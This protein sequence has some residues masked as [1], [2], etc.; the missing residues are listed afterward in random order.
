M[1]PSLKAGIVALASVAL[2]TAAVPAAS[3][4]S[5]RNVAAVG[6]TDGG[7]SLVAFSTASTRFRGAARA[8]TG[9]TGDTRLVGIDR[10]V[11][12]RKLYGVGDRGGVYTLGDRGA[13][14]KVLQLTVALSGT[15][16]GV[17]F[18]PAAN[19]L[20]IVSDTGQNL[21]QPFATAGAAT[22][23]DGALT[24]PAVAPATGTVPA[25]G[26]TGAAYT[27]ND[28]DA[29]SSTTLFDL[30]TALDRVALQSPANAG[31]LASTGGLGVDAALDAGFDV[32]SELDRARAEENTAFA[33]LSVGGR[34]GLYEIDL[35]AG[36]VDRIGSFDRPVTDLA[37]ALDR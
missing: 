24:N 23:V 3:A 35:L 21:R 32:Y 28:L 12:D 11:Q 25:T 6:L 16:F 14:T 1:R 17:D 5:S 4:A 30:D 13:A 34:Y 9:L 18:N 22:V 29:A 19:A 15:A 26:V 27:N 31:T 2:L 37:V 8:V 33:T 7:T 10:R 36:Q 20:R